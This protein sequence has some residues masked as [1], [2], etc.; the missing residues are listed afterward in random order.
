MKKKNFILILAL[1]FLFNFVNVNAQSA[2][3]LF[4]KNFEMTIEGSKY[5]SGADIKIKMLDPASLAIFKK[6]GIEYDAASG[7]VNFPG[8]LYVNKDGKTVFNLIE[9]GELKGV[10][11]IKNIADEFEKAR[12]GCITTAYAEEAELCY[13]ERIATLLRKLDNVYVN[14]ETG[15]FEILKPLELNKGDKGWTEFK[16]GTISC[17]DLCKIGTLLNSDKAKEEIIAKNV[18][19]NFKDGDSA[20]ISANNEASI[21]SFKG[22]SKQ[23]VIDNFKTITYH[24]VFDLNKDVVYGSFTISEGEDKKEIGRSSGITGRFTGWFGL[25]KGWAELFGKN[26]GCAI[27]SETFFAMEPR[28]TLKKENNKV[29]VALNNANSPNFDCEMN[30]KTDKVKVQTFPPASNEEINSVNTIVSRL[31]KGEKT[32]LAWNKKST[33]AKGVNIEVDLLTRIND[34]KEKISV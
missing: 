28:Q 18:N 13:S 25:G 20:D 2:Q 29:Y 34:I 3:E 22:G 32:G 10:Y 6:Y 30:L 33:I 21:S 31:L 5:G 9:G 17:N 19:I 11:D 8:G 1:I 16:S 12:I 27:P 23:K 7:L 15:K 14:L 26:Y 24:K 4:G